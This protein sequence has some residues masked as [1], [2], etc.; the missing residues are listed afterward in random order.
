MRVLVLWAA[1]AVSL[2]FPSL[3]KA[4]NTGRIECARSDEYVYLYSSITTLQVRAT[5]QC[6]ELV[7]ITLR[8]EYY[9]GVKTAKGETGYVPQAS[10]VVLKDEPAN[11]S[12]TPL[13]ELPRE[14]THYDQRPRVAAAP[15]HVAPGFMLAKDTVVHVKLVRTIS[16]ATAHIGDPADMEVAED[17]VVDGVTVLPKGS[18]VTAV[19]AEAEPKKRFG[20]G[21]K[22]AISMTSLRLADGQQ[23]PLRSYEESSGTASTTHMGS[24]KDAVMAENSEFA[25]LV[26]ADVHLKRE[27]FENSKSDSHTDNAP[28]AQRS[29]PQR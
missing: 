28:T 14:T 9:Y 12:P 7:Y 17:V 27:D 20:H 24:G 15:P 22:L 21:G 19:I 8:Y 16:S 3:G 5:L 10:V 29:Q 13:T 1:V 4:Q 6:G 25:V 26:D 2:L 18:R 11:G 23:A